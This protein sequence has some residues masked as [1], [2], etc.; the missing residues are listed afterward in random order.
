MRCSSSAIALNIKDDG[1]DRLVRALAAETGE[2]LTAAVT[3]AV[4]E[5]LAGSAEPRRPSAAARR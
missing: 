4:R 1:A 2:S 3:V 5:R